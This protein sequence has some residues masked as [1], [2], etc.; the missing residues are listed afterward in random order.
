MKLDKGDIKELVRETEKKR[1]EWL[2]ATIEW[3]DMWRMHRYKN[4]FLETRE[5]DQ[6]EQIVTA[7]PYNIVNL[8]GRFVSNDMRLEIPYISAKDEDDLRSEKMEEWATSFWQRSSRQQGRNIIEDMTWFSSVRGRGAM[9]ILWIED[10][11]P[12]GLK[13]KMLPVLARTLDPRN[14]GVQRGPYWTDYAYHKHQATRADVMQE[15]PGFK[16][17]DTSEVPWKRMTK[18]YTVI[19]VYWLDKGSIWHAVTIDDEY[20]KKPTKTDYGEVPIVEWYADGAPLMDDELAKSLSILHPIRDLWKQ[21]CDYASAIGTG[22]LYYFDPLIKAMGFHEDIEV[23]PGAIVHLTGE[24]DIQ[25]IRGEPNV[26]MAEK[27]MALIQTSIDQATFPGVL[28]GEQPGGV[29]AGFAI[30]SLAAQARNRVNTIRSNLEGALEMATGQ[31]FQLVEIFG[32]EEGVMLWGRSDRSD[33]SRP[34]ML[35]K[36]DIKGD[37]ANEVRLIPEIPTD[38]T[39]RVQIWLQMVREGIVSAGTM[40]N[41]GLNLSLPRDEETR[42]AVEKAI[43]TPELQQKATL[44]ALQTRYKS[45][46]WQLHIVGTP[47]EPLYEAEQQWVETKRQEKEAAQEQRKMEKQQKDMEAALA[48]LPPEALMAMGMNPGG[49]STG[50]PLSMPP[51]QPPMP[52]DMGGGG[53]PGM[54]PMPPEMGGMPPG[55]GM[56]GMP[57]EMGPMQPPGLTGIS[58]ESAGQLTPEMLGIPPTAPPGTFN[59]AIGEPLTDEEIRQQMAARN[60]PAQL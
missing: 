20:A 10:V 37:Y 56:P 11:L 41:R 12:K 16:F 51:G 34:I 26:P 24:Q 40:R 14:V 22:I 21:K 28:Y 23:G 58:P 9:Q 32:K 13:N 18:E 5:V 39:G 59:Q 35:G 54:P 57:P 50:M 4:P 1:A 47:L 7:D 17:K 3:E 2:A 29:Q 8:V 49:M 60:G 45:E 30:N 15:Y 52:P 31:L 38:E 33:R 36:K 48:N 6:R 43:Q 53:M 19:D 55:M 27:L 44:R 42:I 25:F 46:D